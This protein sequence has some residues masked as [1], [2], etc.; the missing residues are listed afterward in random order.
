[1]QILYFFSFFSYEVKT[2]VIKV[3]L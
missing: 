3:E 1:L 2:I